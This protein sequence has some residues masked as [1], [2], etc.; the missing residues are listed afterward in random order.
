MLFSSFHSS[1]TK[2]YLVFQHCLPLKHFFLSSAFPPKLSPMS[3]SYPNAAL[4]FTPLFS[5]SSSRPSL[6]FTP[7]RLCPQHCVSSSPPLSP[8]TLI[9]S[10]PPLPLLLVSTTPTAESFTARYCGWSILWLGLTLYVHPP[11]SHAQ[12]SNIIEIFWG[13]VLVPQKIQ[14]T[15]WCYFILTH[16]CSGFSL[17][18]WCLL[19]FILFTHAQTPWKLFC[20]LWLCFVNESMLSIYSTMFWQTQIFKLRLVQSHWWLQRELCKIW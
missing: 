15:I 17:G 13:T 5:S 1:S 6:H 3:P 7:F 8:L 12:A 9:L 16:L 14:F 10:S 4:S 11:C 2:H 20:T 18:F 19:V